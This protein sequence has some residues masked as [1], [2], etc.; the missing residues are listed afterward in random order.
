MQVSEKNELCVPL[1]NGS[2]WGWPWRTGKLRGESA[3]GD[4]EV[5]VP[6]N[7]ETGTGRSGTHTNWTFQGV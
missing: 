4:S 3:E 7:I 1:E 2:Q 6:C 5:Q